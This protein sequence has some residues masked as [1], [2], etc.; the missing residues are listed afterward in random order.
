MKLLRNADPVATCLF[1]AWRMETDI[2]ELTG[3]SSYG[4]HVTVAGTVTSTFAVSS[5]VAG[6]L[7]DTAAEADV[8]APTASAAATPDTAAIRRQI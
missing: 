4:P 6:R 3:G 1:T 2:D 5:A 8:G 7:I